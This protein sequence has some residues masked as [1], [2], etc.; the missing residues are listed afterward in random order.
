MKATRFS[1]YYENWYKPSEVRL[2]LHKTNE[3]FLAIQLA[4]IKEYDWQY[5]KILFTLRYGPI[6]V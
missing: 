1:K 5:A 4:L 3:E 6:K 2:N